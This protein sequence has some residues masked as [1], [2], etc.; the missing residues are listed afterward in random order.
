MF[1]NPS[2]RTHLSPRKARLTR[3]DGARGKKK[4]WRPYVR[5]WGLSEANVLYWRKCLW[6]CWD[7]SASPG[8]PIVI[9]RRGIYHLPCL[10]GYTP[11][12]DAVVHKLVMF[13]V[14]QHHQVT[15]P[16]TLNRY[17]ETNYCCCQAKWKSYIRVRRDYRFGKWHTVH[18]V[19]AI[20][21][22]WGR[23]GTTPFG[24]H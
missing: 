16:R 2:P 9:R 4:V 13:F 18:R 3:L 19:R 15:H 6:H 20:S 8:A 17:F 23:R 11:D 10:P 7:F 5:I 22:D 21:C 24:V 14:K 12:A 1:P